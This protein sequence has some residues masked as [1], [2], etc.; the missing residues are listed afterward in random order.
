MLEE[1]DWLATGVP[2]STEK[3][4][5]HS[6]RADAEQPSRSGRY[7]VELMRGVGRDVYRIV[8]SND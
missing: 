5:V 6:R 1:S 3:I 8:G 4:L 2:T 7:V